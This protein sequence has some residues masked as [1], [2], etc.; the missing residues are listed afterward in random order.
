M[1]MDEMPPPSVIQLFESDFTELTTQQAL[2]DSQRRILEALERQRDQYVIDHYG[3]DLSDDWIL[4]LV[5]GN[6]HRV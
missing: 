4:D 2:I 3:I 1:C 5:E 6:V